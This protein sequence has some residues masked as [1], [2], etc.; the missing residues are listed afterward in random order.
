MK[1]LE[2]NQM[3]NLQGGDEAA[4]LECLVEGMFFSAGWGALLGG[5]IG[6]LGGA[7]GAAVFCLAKSDG[8]Q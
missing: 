3:E 1:T 6:A 5:P 2:L 4:D 8:W 7:L